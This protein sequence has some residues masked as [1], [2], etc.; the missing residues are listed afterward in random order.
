MIPKMWIR[1]TT[2]WTYMSKIFSQVSG[3]HELEWWKNIFSLIYLIVFVSQLSSWRNLHWKVWRQIIFLD[4]RCSK[5]F[6]KHFWVWQIEIKNTLLF[7]SIQ[8]TFCLLIDFL[9][10]FLLKNIRTIIFFRLKVFKN[11]SWS[12]SEIKKLSEIKNAIF[13]LVC[14][15]YCISSNWFLDNIIA[16]KKSENKYFL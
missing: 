5:D 10:K 11:I 4:P 9:T 13:F 2:G 15:I 7:C 6:I 1:R 3:F 12:N 14:S 16:E 8:F